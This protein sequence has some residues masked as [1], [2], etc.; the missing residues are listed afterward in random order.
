MSQD[1]L[2]AR[3]QAFAQEYI[4]AKSYIEAYRLAGY[5]TENMKPETI[6][7]RAIDV[8]QRPRVA[9]R[10]AQLQAE[11]AERNG[12]NLDRVIE[13]LAAVAFSDITRVVS[14]SD[15]EFRVKSFEM[16][17]NADQRAIKK[18]RV[19]CAVEGHGKQTRHIEYIE[20]DLHDKLAALDKLARHL[21]LYGRDNTQKGDAS[22]AALYEL[23]QGRTRGLPCSREE[24]EGD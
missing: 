14:Y 21:G 5:A 22:L 2:T 16:L 24:E 15:G 4:A 8:A 10:I 11:A 23:V 18:V 20:I 3:E 7:R 6:S 1:V 9:A 13:D 19:R 12:V 17:S